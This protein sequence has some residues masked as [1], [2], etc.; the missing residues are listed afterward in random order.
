MLGFVPVMEKAP[1]LLTFAMKPY[2]RR[3]LDS[4]RVAAAMSEKEAAMC[5][6]RAG[7][8]GSDLGVKK[9]FEANGSDDAVL[10]S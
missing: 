7:G 8:V 1:R 10:I 2:G 3:Q 5:C 6:A 4:V 9:R